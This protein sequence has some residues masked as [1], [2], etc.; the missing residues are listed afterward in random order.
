[1]WRILLPD[2]AHAVDT[3]TPPARPDTS[4]AHWTDAL[5][6][7]AERFAPERPYWDRVLADPPAPLAPQD[8]A[9]A[10]HT[11]GELRTELAPGLTAPLL[12]ATAAAFHARP[13]ELLLAALV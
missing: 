12:T 9:A 3:G 1:S 11:P 7:D 13:D 4:F 8:A 5:Y 2:L 10:P 6:G